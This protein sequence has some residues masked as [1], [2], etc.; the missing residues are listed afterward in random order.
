MSQSEAGARLVRESKPVWQQ[1]LNTL[2]ASIEV[3]FQVEPDSWPAGREIIY[4]IDAPRRAA[5]AN[6][7]WKSAIASVTEKA[8]GASLSRNASRFVPYRPLRTKLTAKYSPS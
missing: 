7:R 6:S 1:Q 5:A 3:D 8:S 2:A 4:L